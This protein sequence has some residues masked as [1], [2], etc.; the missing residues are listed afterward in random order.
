[1]VQ[2]KLVTLSTVDF[3][4]AYKW[5]NDNKIYLA[6]V[7]IEVPDNKSVWH[8]P[9]GNQAVDNRTAVNVGGVLKEAQLLSDGIEKYG[10]RVIRTPPLGKMD[11]KKFKLLTGWNKR[12]NEHERDA[13]RLALFGAARVKRGE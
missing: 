10:V 13:G 4:G 12:S 2:E 11:A 3:W 8:P 5:C 9:T 1:M 7:V 6:A